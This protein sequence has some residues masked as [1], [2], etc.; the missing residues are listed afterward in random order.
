MIIGD[1]IFHFVFLP[2]S[3]LTRCSI[4]VKKKYISGQVDTQ[5]LVPGI[6]TVNILFTNLFF[7]FVSTICLWGKSIY[8]SMNFLIYEKGAIWH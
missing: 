3:I 7:T 1:F 4:A 8:E 5:D 2:F 6:E